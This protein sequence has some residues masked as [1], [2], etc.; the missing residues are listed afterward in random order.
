[1]TTTDV[2]GI[3]IHVLAGGRGAIAAVCW[4]PPLEPPLSSGGGGTLPLQLKVEPHGLRRGT[5]ARDPS[6]F[7]L[8]HLV[9]RETQ[10]LWGI[11]P[12]PLLCHLEREFSVT[13]GVRG[14]HWVHEGG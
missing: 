3:I 2:T 7:H 1:M 10:G 11:P 14:M 4:P 8:L 13:P 6:V 9:R 12:P 5:T